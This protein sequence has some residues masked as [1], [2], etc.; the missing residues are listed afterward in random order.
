MEV[1]GPEEGGCVLGRRFLEAV[2]VFVVSGSLV[3]VL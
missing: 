2:I 3:P 1:G